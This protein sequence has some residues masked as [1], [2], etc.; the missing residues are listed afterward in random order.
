MF[1]KTSGITIFLLPFIGLLA[2][3]RYLYGWGA[4]LP[5]LLAVGTT[6]A[7]LGC[8]VLGDYIYALGEKENK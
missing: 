1:L 5:L 6:G 4:I 3:L 7:I 8:F 2:I